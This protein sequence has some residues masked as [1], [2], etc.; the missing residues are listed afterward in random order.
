MWRRAGEEL[1]RWKGSESRC[2]RSSIGLA[3]CD[4]V[5]WW[6][7]I[8]VAV[9]MVVVLLQLPTSKAVQAFRIPIITLPSNLRH[10]HHLVVCLP[11]LSGEVCHE[12]DNGRQMADW[13]RFER[14]LSDKNEWATPAL[15]HLDWSSKSSSARHTFCSKVIR[16]IM[17]ATRVAVSSE[18]SQKGRSAPG[19]PS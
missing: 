11:A 10:R 15:I 7:L 16:E 8:L 12:P 14:N 6:G 5:R 13:R 1:R 18:E 17:S 19:E 4:G 2:Q 9:V 3:W